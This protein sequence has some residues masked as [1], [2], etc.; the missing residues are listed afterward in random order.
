MSPSHIFVLSDIQSTNT[1]NTKHPTV[2]PIAST[3]VEQVVKSIKT[4]NCK[5]SLTYSY[6][7]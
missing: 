4:T 5:T 6:H 7:N 3:P 1:E 2:E